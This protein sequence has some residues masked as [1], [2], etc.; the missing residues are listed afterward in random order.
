MSKVKSI[1]TYRQKK[2]LRENLRAQLISLASSA[3][4]SVLQLS[5]KLFELNYSDLEGPPLWTQWGFE[6]L[7]DYYE[8]E[9]GLTEFEASAFIEIWR[10]FGRHLADSVDR[11]LLSAPGMSWRKLFHLTSLTT[12]ANVN[13][14]LAKAANMR[15]SDLE[16]EIE[17]ADLQRR[18]ISMAARI[19]A[20]LLRVLT[21]SARMNEAEYRIVS[22]VFEVYR[23]LHGPM[24]HGEFLARVCSEAAERHG[25][26][27][28]RAKRLA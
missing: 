1:E 12:K 3:E 11:K 28:H 27:P 19:K 22:H 26:K 21:W 2:S 7:T 9:L 20:S 4:R 25:V 18:P 24:T 6:S 14:K 8:R 10:H 15:I 17:R 5:E 13:A 23:Q 16:A